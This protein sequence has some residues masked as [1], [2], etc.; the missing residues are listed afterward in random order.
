MQM[1]R[2]FTASALSLSSTAGAGKVPDMVPTDITDAAMAAAHAI[3]TANP[4]AAPEL[5]YKPTHLVM[6][7]IENIHL[8]ADVPYWTSIVIMT[9]GLRFLMLPLAIKTVQNAARMT[10]LRPHMQRLQDGFSKDPHADDM[11]VKLKFQNDMKALF[12]QHKVNPFRSLLMPL[13]QLPVFISF[14]LGLQAMPDMFPGL[15]TGGTLW[16]TDL[17]SKDPYLI[18]PVL[19]AVS[20]LFMIEMG[21]DG[22]QTSQQET[23]RWAM[24]GLAL[25]MG[26]LTMSIPQVVFI[27]WTT[28]NAFSIVQTVVL[29]Q[30]AIRTALEI[31]KPPTEEQPALKM[32][33]PFTM[34]ADAVKKETSRNVDAKAEI[35]DAKMQP[36]PPPSGAPPPVTFAAPPTRRKKNN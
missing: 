19:N 17:G 32:K 23:F 8:T 10:V 21:A 6:W 15:A 13:A 16:F 36:P 9:I 30:E 29:K 4:V 35:V 34:L 11:R 20:F 27:Y 14:F 28:N 7:A 5:G 1:T 33:N 3:V 18:F 2:S 24:R 26:P 12:V 25:G 31:P 22:I